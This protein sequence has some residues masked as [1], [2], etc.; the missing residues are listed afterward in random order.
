MNIRELGISK[1]VMK[2]D[3]ELVENYHGMRS[4]EQWRTEKFLREHL[5]ALGIS[6]ERGVSLTSF[7]EIEGCVE[8]K[9]ENSAGDTTVE[10][11]KYLAGCDG[12]SSTVRKG[13]GLGFPGETTHETFFALHA[14]LENYDADQCEGDIFYGSNTGEKLSRGFA[15]TMPMPQDGAFL[16]TVDLDPEQQEPWLSAPDDVDHRG[17]RKLLQPTAE[18]ICAVLRARG[19]GPDL[20][21]QPGSARWIAHFRVNSRQAPRYGHG[22]VFLAGDACHC[23]SPLGGQGMNMGF[24]D[25]KN[26]GWKIVACAKGWVED[27]TRLMSSYEE[28]RRG[29]ETLILT[30]IERAQKVASARSPFITFLRG[31]GV[32]FASLLTS[33]HA[34]AASYVAQQ[35]WSYKNGPLARE[36]WERPGILRSLL[37]LGSYRRRQNLHRWLS[38]RV[39]AGDRVPN[40]GLSDTADL[41]SVLKRSEGWTLLLF[42]GGPKANA[43][44]AAILTD[45]TI[46]DVQQLHKLGDRLRQMIPA[47]SG[48]I[49]EVVVFEYGSKVGFDAHAKF[50]ARG[51]C[52]MLVRPDYYVGLRCEPIR[53][54]AVARYYKEV[55][56]LTVKPPTALAPCPPSSKS[57][58]LPALSM[59]TTICLG[60]MAATHVY[61]EGSP[62][63]M[64]TVAA[65]CL[66]TIATVLKLSMPPRD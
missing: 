32:R 47:S 34:S 3:L 50:D 40:T 19:C 2:L 18:D 24:Q 10:R 22:R 54:A 49:G 53:E 44:T 45:A 63:V 11:V 26:L 43:A 41:H 55:V 33:V 57:F 23:H 64:K 62:K 31:R 66:A 27:E 14:T 52:L 29:L 5:A 20:R 59:V 42:Q 36:H 15:F 35:G 51:Q 56:G 28:E 16:M 6:V 37:Q 46:L 61:T 7:T 38:T 30:A 13:L 1:P 4:Q 58:D 12:G 8:C 39:R 60:T 21:V 9:L 65:C 25:A 48:G 17:N